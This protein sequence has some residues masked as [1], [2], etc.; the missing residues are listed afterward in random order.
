MDGYT[1]ISFIGKGHLKDG[2]DG[3]YETTTYQFPDTGKKYETSLFVEAILKTEYRPIKK[4]ILV[5]TVT[6][7]WDL[8]VVDRDNPEKPENGHLYLT[9]NEECNNEGLSRKSKEELES[10]LPGWYNNIPFVIID[11]VKEISRDTIVDIFKKYEKIPG[12]LAD[13]TNILFDITHGFRSMPLL[14]Y[15]SLQLKQF[16]RK[17]ELIYGEMGKGEIS[18]V[19]DLSKY[20]EYNEINSAKRLFDEKLD[21][22]LLADKIRNDWESGAKFL[23]RLTE[24]VEYN[25]TLEITEALKQLKNALKDFNGDEKQEWGVSDVKDTLDKMYNKL[26]V[27]GDEKYPVAKTVW[28][29]SKILREK[30]LTTQAVIAL[31]VA[32]ETAIAEKFA[33]GQPD[34]IGNY[35]WFNGSHGSKTKKRVKPVGDKKLSA[36]CEEKENK[37]LAISLRKLEGFRNRIAHG[38]GQDTQG[39]FPSRAN[40]KGILEPIDDAIQKLF[41]ILDQENACKPVK[42]RH[43]VYCLLNH[44]LT[45]KQEAELRNSF[46]AKQINYPSAEIAE[47]WSKIPTAKELTRSHL[48][49]FTGW[50]DEAEEGDIVVLQGEFCATFALA[51]FSLRKGLIPVCAVAER[52]AQEKREGETVQKTHVFEHIC[53]RRYRYYDELLS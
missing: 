10:K 6:S 31:Q 47:L 34:K 27:K 50:L 36:I 44:K 21:G 24:I 13:N 39:N 28:E 12:L 2:K 15:Q 23:D 29:Y 35:E 45:P 19:H 40:A 16:D 33:P 52:V 53:F 7:S 5:G 26:S 46:R 49:P 43:Y 11:H 14:V 18:P 17:V 4:V 1:L 3:E 22:R 37:E 38:G 8:L 51:N 20:W 25:F 42:H 48:E 9:I 41:T 32:V 30:N